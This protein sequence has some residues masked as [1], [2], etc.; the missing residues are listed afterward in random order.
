[1]IFVR[2]KTKV[3][4][5]IMKNGKRKIHIITQLILSLKIRIIMS[6]SKEIYKNY[7]NGTENN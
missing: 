3:W 4:Q 1:M 6:I 7:D 2:K 5:L